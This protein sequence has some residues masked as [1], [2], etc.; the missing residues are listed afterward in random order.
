[1]S[2]LVW[3]LEVITKGNT[4][5]AGLKGKGGSLEGDDGDVGY[6]ISIS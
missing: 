5:W 2:V 3:T 6:R 4:G 1:M